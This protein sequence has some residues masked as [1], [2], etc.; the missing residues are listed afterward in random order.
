MAYSSSNT[1]YEYSYAE[2]HLGVAGV[3]MRVF[4]LAERYGVRSTVYGVDTGKM[5]TSIIP[6]PARPVILVHDAPLQPLAGAVRS[7]GGVVG[8]YRTARSGIVCAPHSAVALPPLADWP[9]SQLTMDPVSSQ[10][11]GRASKLCMLAACS[12]PL[13]SVQ[14]LSLLPR[15][16]M[17]LQNLLTSCR[18]LGRLI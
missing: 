14:H 16:A 17:G 3:S 8:S 11:G 15:G 18:H 9:T 10:T 1:E 12:A 2:L 7:Q 4:V 5:H 13:Y 6:S